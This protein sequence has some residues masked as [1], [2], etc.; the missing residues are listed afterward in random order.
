MRLKNS[1]TLL[2]LLLAAIGSKAQEGS[3]LKGLALA[4]SFEEGWYTRSA[5]ITFRNEGATR[6]WAAGLRIY[7]LRNSREQ[8][9]DAFEIYTQPGNRFVFGKVNRLLA[10]S[11]YFEQTVVLIP[12]GEGQL[13]DFHLFAQAGPVIGLRRP[14]YVDVFRATGGGG[15]GQP[16]SGIAEPTAF[17]EEIEYTNIV[18]R[19]Q[20]FEYGWDELGIVPGAS[21]RVGGRV[22][23]ARYK[24]Y[25]TELVF[26]IQGDYLFQGTDI[27][28]SEP[29]QQFF[30]N[31]SVGIVVGS[32]W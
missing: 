24:R 4:A 21:M 19:S 16:I 29:G 15:P 20:V 12:H 18:G 7:G 9:V 23:L 8:Y 28:V 30:T 17:N 25:L 6:P 1:I 11:P 10:I 31:L 5:G 2:L 13:F 26:S 32:R 3:D 14:Y 22:G 27:L